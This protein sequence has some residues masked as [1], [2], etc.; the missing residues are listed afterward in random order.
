M[1]N[2]LRYVWLSTPEREVYYWYLVIEA[3]R[4]AAKYS[5]LHRIAF[6]NKEL[7]G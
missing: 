7:P 5:A 4:E 1:S 3:R 6:Y 2:I